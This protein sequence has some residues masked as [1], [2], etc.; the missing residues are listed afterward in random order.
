MNQHV[1]GLLLVDKP[2]G[3]TSHDL[4]IQARKALGIKA[5]GHGGTLDPM[6]SG[7][8]VLLAGE[9]TKL[10]DYILKGDKGYWVKIRLGIETDTLDRTG[11]VLAE[12][13]AD[14]TLGQIQQTIKDLTGE[15]ELE[16]PI[17]SAVRVNGKKLYESARRGVVVEEPRRIVT[18]HE[19]RLLEHGHDWFS[20]EMKCSKGSFV[21]SWAR[22]AGRLLGTGA[23]VEGL[24]RT[25]SG[26]YRIDQAI[27]IEMLQP[28]P[29][30]LIPINQALPEWPSIFVDGKDR[31]LL[32]NGQISYRLRARLQPYQEQF[33]RPGSLGIKVNG[34]SDKNLLALLTYR[35]DISDFG[36]ERV[37][38]SSR[39]KN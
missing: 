13:T 34:Q 28:G 18:F 36:I 23:V 27:Q 9:G 33:S 26:P 6:A 35:H 31:T 29:S 10:A 1:D 39:N 20:V 19:V 15:L 25:H 38:V 5:I 21:R 14:V 37:F 4:V 17:F 2:E 8:L 7:L 11:K 12:K 24:R 22:A 32:E 16:V 30:S 3:C